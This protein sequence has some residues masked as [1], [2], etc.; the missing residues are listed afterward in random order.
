MNYSGFLPN[1]IRQ[2]A[3]AQFRLFGCAHGAWF[4]GTGNRS[5]ANYR[6]RI[7]LLGM[8]VTQDGQ[9]TTGNNEAPVSVCE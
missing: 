3:G 8:A 9:E 7:G 4:A 1:A 5:K 2:G 6:R